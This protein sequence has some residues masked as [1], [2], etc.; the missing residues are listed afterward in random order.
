M[1]LILRPSL[2]PS[3]LIKLAAWVTATH[4]RLDCSA[5]SLWLSLLLS[6]P[7][8]CSQVKVSKWNP[9]PAVPPGPW[10]D[11]GIQKTSSWRR[12]GQR[13]G[14]WHDSQTFRR[15]WMGRPRLPGL[16]MSFTHKTSPRVFQTN[17]FAFFPQMLQENVFFYCSSKSLPHL[18]LIICSLCGNKFS[19]DHWTLL[20]LKS[21]E[22]S[23]YLMWETFLWETWHKLAF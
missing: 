2:L 14:W 8:M 22:N 19:K 15:R 6:L 21:G 5:V 17:C 7:F 18:S 10:P 13:P 12:R 9:S 4:P 23:F 16:G 3:F 11:V 20:G 1:V